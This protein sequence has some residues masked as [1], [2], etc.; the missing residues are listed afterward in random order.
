MENRV[1][2][3]I[4]SPI[5]AVI[6]RSQLSAVERAEALAAYRWGKAFASLLARLFVSDKG[7]GSGGRKQAALEPGHSALKA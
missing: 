2:I 1:H 6:Q 7:D 3:S 5:M 4:N